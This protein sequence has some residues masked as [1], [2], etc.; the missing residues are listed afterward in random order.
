VDRREKYLARASRRYHHQFLDRENADHWATSAGKTYLTEHGLFDPAHPSARIVQ[1]YQLGIVIKPLPGDERFEGWL[2]IPYL[3]R[4]GVKAIRFRNLK[5]DGG[6]KIGQAKGQQ[7]RLYN[8]EALFGPHVEIGIAEGE[9]DA[10]AAT[11]GLGL[12]TVGLPG[13][14]QWV[15]Y[16]NIW[17]PLFKDFERVFILRDGDTAGQDM[18]D[19]I[20]ESLKLKARVINMPDEEDVSSMLVQGRAN[21]LT[22]Q[23]AEDDEDD[24]EYG[25]LD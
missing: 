22:K 14:N 4:R 20:T 11:E 12:P 13:A 25:D 24:D 19:A 23:F 16:S 2:S 5:D 3:T 21:E 15:A 9:I 1:K 10:V 17:A 18:A 8:P 7:S 6:P